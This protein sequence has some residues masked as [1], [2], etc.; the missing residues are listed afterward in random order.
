VLGRRR[1]QTLAAGLGSRRVAGQI[2][3]V[4]RTL[5]RRRQDPA[6]ASLRGR[7]KVL[8]DSFW[9]EREAS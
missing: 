4:Y 6:V 9:P 1:G 5:G 7:L 2:E 3:I 8:A